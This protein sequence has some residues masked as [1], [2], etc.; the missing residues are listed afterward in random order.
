VTT[1][2]DL[3]PA[4]AD[5]IDAVLQRRS[6]DL[7]LEELKQLGAVLAVAC[8]APDERRPRS[9]GQPAGHECRNVTDG[10]QLVHF[11]FHDLRRKA[12]GVAALPSSA[13]P[14]RDRG[15]KR[16]SE[17]VAADQRRRASGRPYPG[18]ENA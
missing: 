14:V 8:P 1:A 5:L 18:W 10:G 17:T 2:P 9:C 11:Q 15:P 12:A 13:I 6:R 16:Q 7:T 4:V 3:D